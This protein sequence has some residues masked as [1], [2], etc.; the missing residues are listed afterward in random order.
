MYVAHMNRHKLRVSHASKGAN[1]NQTKE[2]RCEALQGDVN[3]KVD[4]LAQWQ[5]ALGCE[6][7]R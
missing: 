2:E 5:A 1:E 3:R 4:A 6:E 7:E